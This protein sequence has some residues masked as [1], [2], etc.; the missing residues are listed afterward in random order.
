MQANAGLGA[1]AGEELL[2]LGFSWPWPSL[3]KA[4]LFKGEPCSLENPQG[5]VAGGDV[6]DKSFGKSLPLLPQESWAG[7]KSHEQS[8]N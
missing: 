6:G 8:G 3:F 1:G 2:L 7:A 4:G 5:S